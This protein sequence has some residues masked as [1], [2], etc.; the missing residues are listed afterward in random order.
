M[1]APDPNDASGEGGI[2][3]SETTRLQASL[4]GNPNKQ[5]DAT[6]AGAGIELFIYVTD[7]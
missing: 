3:I 4:H 2:H 6:F 7:Y 1:R 5:E